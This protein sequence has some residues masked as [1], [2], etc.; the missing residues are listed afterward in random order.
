MAESDE[1]VKK[2]TWYVDGFEYAKSGPPYS[3]AWTVKKGSHTLLA[4]DQ[5]GNSD[6]ITFKVE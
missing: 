2:L 6:E 5:E 1:P 3:A 4:V